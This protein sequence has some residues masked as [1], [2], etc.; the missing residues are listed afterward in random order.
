LPSARRSEKQ[1][2]G[3]RIVTKDVCVNKLIKI[4]NSKMRKTTIKNDDLSPENLSVYKS[5][6][7]DI[8]ERYLQLI[9]DTLEE[10][11]KKIT[12]MLIEKIIGTAQKYKRETM[13]SDDDNGMESL[14]ENY[15]S[16]KQ[17]EKLPD[18]KKQEE[19]ISGICYKELIDL[20]T[21]NGDQYNILTLYLSQASFNYEERMLDDSELEEFFLS[22]IK[23]VA[24]NYTN[25]H[26]A[27]FVDR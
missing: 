3:E 20:K 1:T 12:G 6:V 9:W 2:I 23:S 24:R 18:F 10:Q 22:E 4:S 15:C 13:F 8:D 17:S 26:I 11:G 16:Q 19:L 7:C 21:G 5:K 14:W 27:E 25:K